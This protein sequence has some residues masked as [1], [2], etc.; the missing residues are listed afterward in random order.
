MRLNHGASNLKSILSRN[1]CERA[2]YKQSYMQPLPGRIN[3]ITMRL[4]GF[5]SFKDVRT[6]R[7][8]LIRELLKNGTPKAVELAE[9]LLYC[10]LEPC[11]SPA[12]PC[13]MRQFRR[14]W[15]SAVTDFFKGLS[16]IRFVTLAPTDEVLERDELREFDIDRFS[17][18]IRRR[19]DRLDVSVKAVG[20]IEMDFDDRLK[21]WRPHVHLIVA[22][23][24][25]AK[26]LHKL[27]VK[28]SPK[29]DGEKRRHPLRVDQ[30]RNRSKQFSYLMKAIWKRKLSFRKNSGVE[31]KPNELCQAMIFRDQHKLTDF[32]FP[33]G[34][35]KRGSSFVLTNVHGIK[36]QSH[37]RR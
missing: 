34:V 13:C 2:K 25:R 15:F 9:K 12:C 21:V 17:S 33:Y 1:G 8:S 7:E 37:K 32:I 14:W 36:S 6:R 20:G 28:V 23:V 18:R 24:T 3:D 11:L 27:N 5:E 10:S 19:L 4:K 35:T 29:V 22:G 30:V 16:D 31:L 26:Q